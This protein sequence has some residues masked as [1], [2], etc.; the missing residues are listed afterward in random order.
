MGRIIEGFWNCAYCGTQKIRGGISQCP[1]CGKPRDENTVFDFDRENIHYVSDE[2]AKNISRNPDWICEYCNRLN[3]DNDKYC[4]SCGSSRTNN[5]LNYFEK[6]ISKDIID[7]SDEEY[8]STNR[9]IKEY[10]FSDECNS[11][12]DKTQNHTFNFKN[13]VLAHIS[14]IL[15]ALFSVLCIFGLLFLIIP[16]EQEI[17]IQAV[18]WE[19]CIYIEK[20]QTVKESNCSLPAKATLLYTR[21]EFSH[22]DKVLDHYVTKS[23]EV[24]KQ[25][26]SHYEDYVSGHRDLG[27]G[28]FEEIKST[29]PVYESYYETEEYEEPVYKYVDV[30]KTKYYYEIDKWLYDHCVET[31]GY[32][33]KPYWGETNLS[34]NERISSK[35]ECYYITG[36]NK[37]DKT[38]KVSLSYEDWTSII[39]GETVKMKVSLNNGIIIK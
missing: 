8:T 37:K 7:N 11:N 30:Y 2:E 21:D 6:H 27:N 39:V 28:F 24:K 34:V 32:N 29:R 5:N 33:K 4:T 23:R 14:S 35:E 20:Y 12:S 36:I 13:F 3:S 26:I 18:S 31:N 1:K 38:V 17:K 10:S 15:I 19:R 22:T 16:S 25:R 9:S